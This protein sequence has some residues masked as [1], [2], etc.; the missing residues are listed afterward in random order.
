MIANVPYIVKRFAEF[1]ELCF[2][3][4]LPPVRMELSNAKTFLGQCVFKRR[5]TWLGRTECYD[6]RLRVNARIDLPERELDDIIL[7]EMIHYYIA[8]NN[9]SDSSAH[10]RVFRRM[11][12]EINARYGRNI[13]VSHRSTAAEREQLY[14]ARERY[15]VVAVVTFADG[16]TGFK[17]LPRVAQRILDYYNK[18]GALRE[19]REVELF[20]SRDIFFNRF[21]N[22]GKLCVHYIERPA[23]DGHLVEAERMRCD[24]RH[25]I[26]GE[27]VR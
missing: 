1:N 11:M 4:Q 16:R 26:R 17:V 3:G 6:F 10:G 19:V 25:I 22:S 27:S 14:D 7:H 2:G 20:M 18:V 9:I 21:P 23:L 13:T 5:R 8:V 24:G 15:H 12:D